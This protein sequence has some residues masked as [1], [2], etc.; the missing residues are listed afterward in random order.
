MLDYNQFKRSVKQ[1]I[2]NHPDGSVSD[3]VDFCEEQIPPAAFTANQWLVEETVSWYRHIL[4]H[5]EAETG[6]PEESEEA[7]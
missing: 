4:A 2:R 5:S 6:A 7:C 1:W 3:L